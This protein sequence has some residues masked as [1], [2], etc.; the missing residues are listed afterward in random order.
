MASMKEIKRRKSSIESTGQITKAMK[1]VATVK[2]QK[3]KQIATDSIP[4]FNTIYE[5]VNEILKKSNNVNSKCVKKSKGGKIGLIVISSN[6]G[7]AGGYNSNIIRAL[8]GEEAK[9]NFDKNNT[10][11]Y[12]IGT[13][14]RDAL[15]RKGFTIKE[16]YNEAI[17][18]PSVD[19]SRKI[20]ETVLNDFFSDEIDEIYLLYTFFKNTLVHIPRLL[21]V[22]PIESSEISQEEKGELVRKNDFVPARSKY[23]DDEKTP[24][25][26]EPGD[27]EILNSIVPTYL[28]SLIYGGMTSSIASENG[29]RMTA[30]DNA[31]NNAN[32]LIEELSLAYN[33]ARQGAITQEL[34]EIVAGANAI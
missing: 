26:Y 17:D 12:A 27:E 11:V 29:A 5:T 25:N 28:T 4:Y 19:L 14:A 16:D 32:E 33:R 7:L 13:K 22:L 10:Y 21:K 24:M 9:V 3:T 18:K 2:L 23:I 31:T 1:L 30:M 34:T 6:K 20:A 15:E 8:I